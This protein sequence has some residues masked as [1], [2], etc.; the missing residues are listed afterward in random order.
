LESPTVISPVSTASHILTI[1]CLRSIT[2][3][4]V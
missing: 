3:S 2:I 4:R 1:D